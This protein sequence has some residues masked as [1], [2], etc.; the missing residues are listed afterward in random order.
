LN[1]SL[2]FVVGDAKVTFGAGDAFVIELV[3]DARKKTFG[4][5]KK[6]FGWPKK[7]IRMAEKKHSDG[8]K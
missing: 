6:T 8:R 2:E 1:N 3:H 5:P 4:W 7:N